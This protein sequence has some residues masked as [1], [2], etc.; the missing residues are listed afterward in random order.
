MFTP[1]PSPDPPRSYRATSSSQPSRSRQWDAHL[2]PSRSPSLSSSSSRSS[3]PTPTLTS[4]SATQS[5]TSAPSSPPCRPSLQEQHML[6]LTRKRKTARRTRWTILLIPL[7]LVIITLS[8]RYISHPALFD[9]LSPE[10]SSGIWHELLDWRPHDDIHAPHLR[11]A[12]EPAPQGLSAEPT[13]TVISFPGQSTQSGSSTSV[14]SS[15]SASVSASSTPSTTSASSTIPTIPATP[16]VLPTP[17][18]QPFSSLGS[19]NFATES[20]Y[21]FFQNMSDTDPF[22]TCRPFSLLVQSSADFI[23]GCC[24]VHPS[25]S[26]I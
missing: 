10:Y 8:T 18:P 11:R 16:P 14:S 2:A 22:R 15:A 26:A 1:P 21:I 4:G 7:A 17:F 13:S 24:I 12:P 19:S 23:N 3:S 20:C 6:S 5:L 9:V 25:A